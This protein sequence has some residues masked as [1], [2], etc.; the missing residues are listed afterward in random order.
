MSMRK[1]FDRELYE[2]NDKL[3]KSCVVEEFN[4]LR[5][6]F[7]VVE[8]PKK[9]GVD[10]LIHRKDKHVFNIETE[11]KRVWKTEEFP[12]TSV[13]FPERKKKFSELDK[14]TIYVMWNSD[15]SA[16]LAVTSEDLK[17]SP[18]AMVRNRYVPY[19]EHFFQVPLENVF[20]NN[21]NKAIKKME[22]Q[23]NV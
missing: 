8:N 9:R 6:K 19:G 2:A 23:S 21:L 15:Q 11:I 12:Y 22:E 20:F 4:K 16:Y 3:A 14:P 10:L 5:K 18:T 17:N 7:E 1:M 13:Q